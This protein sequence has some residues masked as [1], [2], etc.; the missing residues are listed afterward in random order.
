[1]QLVTCDRTNPPVVS[2]IQTPD[3]EK[4][5]L[6]R[7]CYDCHSN[8]TVWRWYH[9]VAPGSWLVHR[10]VVEGRRHLNFSEWDAVPPE[11]RP[12]KIQGIAKAASNGEMPPWWYLYPLHTDAKVT[13][14]DKA[15]LKSWADSVASQTTTGVGASAPK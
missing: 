4:A 12:R 14:A 7:A 10:D 15:L 9:K 3:D 6:R 8:E 2:D 13:D 1:M 5:V 11:K